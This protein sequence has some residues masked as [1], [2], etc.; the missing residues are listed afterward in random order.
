[1]VLHQKEINPMLAHQLLKVVKS[2]KD[3]LDQTQ[4]KVE[5]SF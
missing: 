4:T 3:T 5:C 1:M 2:E